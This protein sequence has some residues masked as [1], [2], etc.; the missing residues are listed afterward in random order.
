MDTFFNCAV[1]KSTFR[2]THFSRLLPNFDVLCMKKKD[3]DISN[4]VERAARLSGFLFSIRSNPIR[5]VILNT[6][7]FW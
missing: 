7:L 5:A 6:L 2:G 1:Q 4:I 3:L